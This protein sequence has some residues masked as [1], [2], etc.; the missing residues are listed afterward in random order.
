MAWAPSD[1]NPIFPAMQTLM[2]DLDALVREGW[3]GMVAYRFV[4]LVVES[5]DGDK[6]RGRGWMLD[7]SEPTEVPVVTVGS[8]LGYVDFDALDHLGSRHRCMRWNQEPGDGDVSAQPLV[9]VQPRV[10]LMLPFEVSHTH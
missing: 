7:L 10:L 3:P 4:P 9:R 6:P 5:L 2:A 1:A 8:V